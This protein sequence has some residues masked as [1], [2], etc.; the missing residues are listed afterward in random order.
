MASPWSGIERCA[1]KGTTRP[2]HRHSMTVTGIKPRPLA[3]RGCSAVAPLLVKPRSCPRGRPEPAADFF[4]LRQKRELDQQAY[5]EHL[6]GSVAEV[7]NSYGGP[8]ASKI[9]I[10]SAMRGE[11]PHWGLRLAALTTRA[12]FAVSSVIRVANSSG[13]EP[14]AS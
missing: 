12:H 8:D 10:D 6:T 5:E 4:C 1:G 11:E 14:I 7:C 2:Q 3:A 13:V 9:H